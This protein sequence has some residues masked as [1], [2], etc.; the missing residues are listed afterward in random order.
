MRCVS[1]RRKALLRLG[2]TTS[3]DAWVALSGHLWPRRHQVG[4]F[5]R[6]HELHPRGSPD[7]ALRPRRRP[8]GRADDLQRRAGRGREVHLPQ[9]RCGPDGVRAP[10]ERASLSHTHTHTHPAW[11]VLWACRCGPHDHGPA[12]WAWPSLGSV[13]WAHPALS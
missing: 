9:T 2:P 5:G 8:S 13:L 11:A 10:P 4:C 6:P 12:R 3:A 1:E 7:V